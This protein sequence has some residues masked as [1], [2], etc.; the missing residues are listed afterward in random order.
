[1]KRL[2]V[3]LVTAAAVLAMLTPTASAGF[4]EFGYNYGARLFVGPADGVDR[5]LDGK[6]WGDPTYANDRLVMKWSK[7]W[8]NA[9]FHGAPWGPEAWIT[10]E[11]NGRVPGGSGEGWHYKIIW[12]GPALENSPS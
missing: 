9:R 5:I 2:L 10:N 4:D 12:V 11:W 3:A 7:A 1:M 6:F 8:D